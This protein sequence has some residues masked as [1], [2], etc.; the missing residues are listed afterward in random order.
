MPL[1]PAAA[2]ALGVG[3]SSGVSAISGAI[4]S[5][6]QNKSNR[7]LAE[8]SYSKDLEM[9]HKQNAYNN[10][11]AQMERLKEA[12]LNPN[13]VYG[14]GTVA[15]NTA[16]QLPKYQAPKMDNSQA[17]Q[18]MQNASQHLGQYLTLKKLGAEI[19]YID[20]NTVARNTQT[21]V[22]KQQALQSGLDVKLFQDTYEDKVAQSRTNTNTKEQALRNL[23][24]VNKNLKADQ[25]VKSLQAQAIGKKIT[26]D[27]FEIQ[28]NKHGLSKQDSKFY[29]MLIQAVQDGTLSGK[30][31]SPFKK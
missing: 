2:A 25:K 13:L 3:I 15:G 6:M 10:P 16:S 26:L 20:A 1:L 12:G 17:A 5:G 19:N 11:S 21:D 23:Q 30:A 24:E 14:T 7:E 4:S 22:F 18:G 27:N 29:R 28:L 9:W 31:I 8:Y